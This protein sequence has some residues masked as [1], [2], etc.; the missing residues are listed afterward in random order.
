MNLHGNFEQKLRN[1]RQ[2]YPTLW[3]LK[4]SQHMTT[5]PLNFITFFRLFPLEHR[6]RCRAWSRSCYFRSLISFL[7]G[8]Y[9]DQGAQTAHTTEDYMQL[10]LSFLIPLSFTM[11]QSPNLSTKYTLA[12]WLFPRRPPGWSLRI[13][14][15]SNFGD[16]AG[17]GSCRCALHPMITAHLSIC[18]KIYLPDKSWTAHDDFKE[19]NS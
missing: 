12:M 1:K 11:L 14:F 7:L 18:W 15:G 10:F 6:Q 8:Q 19:K 9:L 5:S 4:V 17:N 3:K 2:F 16:Q 13:H